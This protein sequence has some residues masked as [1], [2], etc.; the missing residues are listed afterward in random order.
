VKCAAAVYYCF[1]LFKI[2]GI[3]QQIYARY[4]RGHTR[5]GGS[6]T[7]TPGGAAEQA[8]RALTAGTSPS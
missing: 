5:D 6:P 1:G 8:D 2:A 4:V 3:V 7:P